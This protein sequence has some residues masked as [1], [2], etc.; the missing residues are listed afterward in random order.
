MQRCDSS[1]KLLPLEIVQ[2]GDQ[3]TLTSGPFA[4]FVGEVEM[5]APGR[6]VW[7]LMDILGG[8]TRTAV[9]ADQLRR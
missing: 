3:V 9:S 5:I 2:P 6:R 7:V 1:G 4:N 8:Q